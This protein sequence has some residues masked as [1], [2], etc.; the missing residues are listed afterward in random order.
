MIDIS[1][2]VVALTAALVDIPS[3]SGQEAVLAD[4]VAAALREL[5]HLTVRRDGNAVVASTDLGRPQRVVLGGH[6]DTVPA[7]GNLPHRVEAGELAGLGS[8]DMKGGVAVALR[9]AHE[10][11]TPARD[12]TYVFYD[13]E[14]VAADRNGLRRL[15]THQPQWL[16]ADFAILLEPSDARVEAGCQGTLRAQVTTRGKRAHSARSWLG[17]NAIHAAGDVLRRL[18][19]YQPARVM[20]DGLEYREG[21]NAVGIRGGV[22]GNVVPDEA[23]VTVNYRFV[24]S[25]P[26]GWAADHVR[27]VFAGYDVEVVDLAGGALPGLSDP[28]VA[29]F[30]AAVGSPPSAKLGWT[31]VALFAELG[32]PA[33][34]YGPGDPALAHAADER[35]A[36]AQLREC[37]Q[38]L[39]GWLAG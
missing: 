32:V 35:V 2:D 11:R 20:I 5:P 25:R 14:E 18:A 1:G 19:E 31:D 17:E 16:A 27:D 13:C 22:A 23:V 39:L 33:V 7:A 28:T 30:V 3:E 12:V 15:A 24:P 8:C 6:L 21:L 26:A 38:R 36:I 10:L 37:E 34:N 9:C 29:D 4:A